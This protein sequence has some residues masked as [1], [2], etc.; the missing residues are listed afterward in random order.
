MC[1]FALS[2]MCMCVRRVCERGW[3][4]LWS[5]ETPKPSTSRVPFQSCLVGLRGR[6]EGGC[7]GR[8]C[9]EREREGCVFWSGL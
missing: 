4:A 1:L 7:F 9:R 3:L 2:R 5:T 6:R 8:V